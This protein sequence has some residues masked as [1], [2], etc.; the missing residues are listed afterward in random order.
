MAAKPDTR[1]TRMFR[2]GKYN[3]AVRFP[4][5]WDIDPTDAEISYDGDVITVRPLTSLADVFEQISQ[6]ETPHPFIEP[7]D[8]PAEPVDL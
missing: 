1:R 5:D 3:T 4:S 7:D 2:N 8:L 6:R